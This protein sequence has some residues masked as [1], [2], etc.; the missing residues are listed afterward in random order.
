[1]EA[2]TTRPG[3]NSLLPCGSSSARRRHLTHG[4]RCPICWP[5]GGL[6]GMPDITAAPDWRAAFPAAEF[7]TDTPE[8]LAA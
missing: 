5:D 1:M 3:P 7:G 2:P 6:P 8:E 4:Q